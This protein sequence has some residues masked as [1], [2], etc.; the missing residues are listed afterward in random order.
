MK[1]RLLSLLLV[2]VILCAALPVHAAPGTVISNKL[3]A[4]FT[5]R[6]SGGGGGGGG[7]GAVEPPDEY[8]SHPGELILELARTPDDFALNDSL[9]YTGAARLSLAGRTEE[10]GVFSPACIDEMYRKNFG[11]TLTNEDVELYFPSGALSI[12]QLAPRLG[13][14]KAT[15]DISVRE[16]TAEERQAISGGDILG[17]GSGLFEIGG[18]YFDLSA[19]LVTTGP[20][21]TV[22]T[23][24]IH[25]FGGPVRVTVDLT[26][27][28][29]APEDIALLTAVR[30]ERDA[31]G[32]LVPVKLGG[33]YDPATGT[34]S[35]HTDRFSLYTVLRA[36][37][38]T[39]ITL[40]IGRT[41]V[42][43]NGT[44]QTIDTAPVIIDSRTM[45]PLRYV[46]E[47]LGAS[48]L[49]IPSDSSVEIVRQD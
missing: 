29:I 49:W 1:T 38:L 26:G 8:P 43:V 12:P 31:D 5:V 13:D 27:L 19:V 23:E 3:T 37:R 42:L 11:L 7:G 25:A 20:D 34:F 47:W 39:M 48:V 22:T 21:G 28:E 18:R 4:V 17:P 9:Y 36:A 16:A 2:L 6:R 24:P 30:F 15:L 44:A 45:V 14:A 40:Y 32:N 10:K 46:S 35:F 41:D 33:S